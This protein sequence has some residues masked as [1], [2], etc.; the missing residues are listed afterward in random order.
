[1]SGQNYLCQEELRLRLD[2]WR[3]NQVEYY[4]D[5]SLHS[6]TYPPKLED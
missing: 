5:P 1:M 6:R 4:R 2:T 3:K